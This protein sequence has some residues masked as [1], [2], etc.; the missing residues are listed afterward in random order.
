M[1]GETCCLRFVWRSLRRAE[2]GRAAAFS[3]CRTAYG[4]D[5][6]FGKL[7]Q[8]LGAVRRHREVGGTCAGQKIDG[9][10]ACAIALVG[11]RA[12]ERPRRRPIRARSVGGSTRVAQAFP[13]REIALR[14]WLARPP[15]L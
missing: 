6:E 1:A 4:H 15:Y 10:I 9:H 5:A 14:V 8:R 2:G 12:A 11:G 13:S 7:Y 3:L